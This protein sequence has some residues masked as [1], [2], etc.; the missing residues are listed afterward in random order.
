MPDPLGGDCVFRHTE[1]ESPLQAVWEVV[2]T[3]ALLG[4]AV[5]FSVVQ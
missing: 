5:C 1:V 4:L 2:S 3:G